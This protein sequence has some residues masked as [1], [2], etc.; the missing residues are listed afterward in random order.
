MAVSETTHTSQSTASSSATVPSQATTDV[1]ST[2]MPAEDPLVF[3]S[4]LT[5]NANQLTPTVTGSLSPLPTGEGQPAHTTWSSS[6]PASASASA[7]PDKNPARGTIMG[8]DH[9]CV[10]LENKEPYSGPQIGDLVNYT[11]VIGKRNETEEIIIDKHGCHQ[12]ACIGQYGVLKLCN[13]H[14]QGEPSFERYTMGKLHRRLESIRD[15]M[16]PRWNSD[17]SFQDLT[18]PVMTDTRCDSTLGMRREEEG[19]VKYKLGGGDMGGIR[20]VSVKRN[21]VPPMQADKYGN[22]HSMYKHG[23]LGDPLTFQRPRW[24][25]HVDV[26]ERLKG[27]LFHKGDGWGLVVDGPVGNGTCSESKNYK[28]G[29]CKKDD[30]PSC[31]WD[32]KQPFPEEVVEEMFYFGDEALLA[33]GEDS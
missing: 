7:S 8:E 27:V 26:R 21:G 9:Y 20:D 16:R 1:A 32:Y 10:N 29:D 22:S 31:S 24:R 11:N 14:P 30:P 17:I 5:L 33:Q 2:S 6:A 18:F 28:T 12:I 3:H 15:I 25:R 19:Y 4:T 13:L 23:N